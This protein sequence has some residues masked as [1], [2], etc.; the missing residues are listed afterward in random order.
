MAA[1]GRAPARRRRVGPIAG[2]MAYFGLGMASTLWFDNRLGDP[3]MVAL[4]G[5]AVMFVVPAMIRRWQV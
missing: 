1:P 4:A 3:R 5:L 2:D